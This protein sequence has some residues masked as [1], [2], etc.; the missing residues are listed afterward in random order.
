MFGFFEKKEEKEHFG[1]IQHKRK[2]A[3][4]K[5]IFI[6]VLIIIMIALMVGLAFVSRGKTGAATNSAV[7]SIQANATANK[8]LFSG[9]GCGCKRYR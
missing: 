7:T 4:M 1:L 5:V 2:K 9:G 6:F 8:G 3:N